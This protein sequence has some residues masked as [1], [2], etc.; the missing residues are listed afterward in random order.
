MSRIGKKPVLLPE[1]VRVE[2]SGRHVTVTGPRG[3]LERDLPPRTEV[4]IRDRAVVVTPGKGSGRTGRAMWGLTRTLIDNMVLGV[5]HGFSRELVVEGVGYRVTIKKDGWLHLTLG[6]SHPILY[7]VPKVVS[8][9]VDAKANRI[10]LRSIDK[11]KLG[12][13]AATIRSFRPPEPYKGKGIRYGGEKVRRK[14]GKSG[15]K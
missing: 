7:E 8:V 14:V 4:E 13:V 12:L 2:I 9:E 15:V 5:N 10:T 3:R 1:K 11:E 6:F